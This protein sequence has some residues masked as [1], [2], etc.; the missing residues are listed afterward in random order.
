MLAIKD[1]ESILAK[2]YFWNGLSAYI[3]FRFVQL[4]Q[5][6]ISMIKSQ[7]WIKTKY[8]SKLVAEKRLIWRKRCNRFDLSLSVAKKISDGETSK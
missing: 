7:I 4:F 6:V 8:E 5:I 1:V 2:E 3:L